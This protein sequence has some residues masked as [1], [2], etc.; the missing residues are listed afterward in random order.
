VL[1]IRKNVVMVGVMLMNVCPLALVQKIVHN[2]AATLG[3]FKTVQVMAIVVGSPAL[4]TI[5]WTRA[6][7]HTFISIT[8]TI[9]TF[10][11]IPSTQ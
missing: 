6:R 2:A 3:S 4:C 8:P 5:F 9:T 11:R 7:G 1:G 10:L